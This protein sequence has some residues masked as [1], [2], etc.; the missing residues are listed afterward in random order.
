M[1]P[2]SG[3]GKALFLGAMGIPLLA[4]HPSRVQAQ[5]VNRISQR[6]EATLEEMLTNGLKVR[7]ASEKQFIAKV[8]KTVEEGK[9]SESLVKALFQRSLQQH[10]RYPLPYFTAMIQKVAKQRGVE[11]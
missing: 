1:N 8:V 10:S 5:G 7:T 9:L 4:M 2:M 6:E 3:F 11:L